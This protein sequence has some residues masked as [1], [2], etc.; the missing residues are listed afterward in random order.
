MNRGFSL[1]EIL[2]ALAIVATILTIAAPRYFSAVDKTK[3][4]VLREN[5]YIMRDALDK[6]F[7][8]Q[9]KYPP[10][11]RELVAKKYLRTIPVDPFTE[12]ANSWIPIAPEDAALG[13]V[14][15]VRS[16]A[17]NQARDGTWY[18]DW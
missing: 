8:D 3:E 1:I 12:S 10:T 17:P 6:Y 7:S 16:S 15:D 11:L 18:K 4:A 2:V 14:F 5:L 9:G 13:N